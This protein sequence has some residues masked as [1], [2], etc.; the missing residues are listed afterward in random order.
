MGLAFFTMESN[1]LH[2][3]HTYI[4]FNGYGI[5]V[6]YLDLGSTSSSAVWAIEMRIVIYEQSLG[7]TSARPYTF[8]R[9]QAE[10]QQEYHVMLFHRSEARA[11]RVLSRIS[12]A[13]NTKKL[14]H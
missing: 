11:E 13:P 3:I 4:L 7:E 5:Y 8:V 9:I 14:F 2:N 1:V 6:R 12:S 10:S